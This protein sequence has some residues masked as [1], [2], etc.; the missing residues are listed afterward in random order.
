MEGEGV[1]KHVLTLPE[2]ITS[3]SDCY[4]IISVIKGSESAFSLL[5]LIMS[6]ALLNFT[7]YKNLI[8]ILV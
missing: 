3:S 1:S 2:L 4:F 5:S 7:E 8:A 6:N